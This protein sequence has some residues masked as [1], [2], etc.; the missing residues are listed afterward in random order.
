M[1]SLSN[2]R[3]PIILHIQMHTLEIQKEADRQRSAD[4]SD[5]ESVKKP[6]GNAGRDGADDLER[7]GG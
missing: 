5:I 3:R 6:N 2:R 7:R 1:V 4:N